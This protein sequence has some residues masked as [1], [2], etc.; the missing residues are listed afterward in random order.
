MV[1]YRRLVHAH[2]SYPSLHTSNTTILFPISIRFLHPCTALLKILRQEIPKC[3]FILLRLKLFSCHDR[4]LHAS[5]RLGEHILLEDTLVDMFQYGACNATRHVRIGVESFENLGNRNRLFANAPG[6]VV[7]RGR[8][9]RIAKGSSM[10]LVTEYSNAINAAHLSSASRASFASGKTLML[11]MSPPQA[12]YI[13]LSARVENCGPSMHTAVL[14]V[15]SPTPSLSASFTSGTIKFISCPSNG[16]PNIACATTPVSWKNDAG[17]IPLVRSMIWSGMT[18]SPGLIS[19][20]RLPTALN[21]TTARTPICL[22]A[23]MLARAGTAL[24]L[25]LCSLPWRAR[26]AM[27]VPEGSSAIVMG[28]LG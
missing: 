3:L 1:E 6:V 11:I 12:R 14:P 23:A 10:T 7:R 26:N 15:C 5:R 20:R 24:G 27:R 2:L 13:K 25:M 28:E 4:K 18:K 19:S 21:A 8:D 9:K 16:S 22:R 17:R